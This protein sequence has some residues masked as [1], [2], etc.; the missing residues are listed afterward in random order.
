MEYEVELEST[1][2]SD[3]PFSKFNSFEENL[4]FYKNNMSSFRLRFKE[5]NKIKKRLEK[6][7]HKGDGT[8]YVFDSQFLKKENTQS[9]MIWSGLPK[10]PSDYIDGIQIWWEDKT[11]DNFRWIFKSTMLFYLKQTNLIIL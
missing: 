2:K 10:L 7:I 6:L 1:K 5:Y 3:I 8:L 4:N 9:L 11:W